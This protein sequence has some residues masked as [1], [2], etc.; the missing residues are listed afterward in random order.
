MH[1]TL[2][3]K[4]GDVRAL[5][6]KHRVRSL[7]VFGSAASEAFDPQSSDLD[8]VVEFE[9]GPRRGFDDVFF[10]LKEDL[11]RLFGRPI[12]LIERG[13]VENPYLLESIRASGETLYAACPA[14]VPP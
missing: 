8:F 14:D 5:C 13:A 10:L 3:E 4:V 1:R 6:A 11:E 7:I 2:S 12:D 9:P